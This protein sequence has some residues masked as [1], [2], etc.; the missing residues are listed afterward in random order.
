MSK[1][2]SWKAGCLQSPSS[3]ILLIALLLQ[4][5]T[6]LK[7]PRGVPK[8][9][10]GYLKL[11]WDPKSSVEEEALAYVGNAVSRRNPR[12]VR[13]KIDFSGFV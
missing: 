8:P 4:T 9:R 10:V 5:S 12:Q 6:I 7:D 13:R 2:H 1:S 11:C 3:Y